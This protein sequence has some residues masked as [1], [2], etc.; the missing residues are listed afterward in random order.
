[1]AKLR[2]SATALTLLF[3]SIIACNADRKEQSAPATMAESRPVEAQLRTLTEASAKNAPPEF[4]EASRQAFEQLDAS[5]ITET[6]LN[7]GDTAPSFELSDGRGVMVRSADLLAQGPIALVFYR[8]AWCPYCNVYLHALQEYV[9]QFK[10]LGASLVAVSGESPDS[11]LSVEQKNTLTFTVLSDPQFETARRFGIVY[12]QPAVV[13]EFYQEFGLEL[14]SYYGN[15]KPEL[16]LS[17]T[18]VI[19][20]DGI[21]RYAYLDTDYHRR[22]EPSDVLKAIET[23]PHSK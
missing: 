12:E 11:T 6:A 15:A 20:R 7:V 22:A 4:T 1:M 2:I 9:P 21:I 18:Y 10:A 16:P 3:A 14:A 17:A 19:D 13:N 8:G 23:L 5:G